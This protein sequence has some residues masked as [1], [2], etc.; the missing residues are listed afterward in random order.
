MQELLEKVNELQF[1]NYRLQHFD[2]WKLYVIGDNDLSY[3]HGVELILTGVKHITCDVDFY[4][5]VFRHLGSCVCG[6]SGQRLGIQTDS[7]S[8][9]IVFD[10]LEIVTGVVFHY[11]RPNLQPGERIASWIAKSS[12]STT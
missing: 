2:G 11:Q 7:G 9:E 6:C 12:E 8:F 1:F 10:G 5:P 4:H 3:H